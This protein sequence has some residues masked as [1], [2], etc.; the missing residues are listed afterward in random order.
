MRRV[1]AFLLRIIGSFRPAPDYREEMEAHLAMQTDENIR[2]GMSPIEAR[3]AAL[4]QSGGV[5]RGVEGVHEQHGLPWLQETLGDV[6]YAWR[7]LRHNKLYTLVAV[8]TLAL[9]VGAN[10]AIFSVVNGVVLQPLPYPEPERLVSVQSTIG[11]R[12][13]SASGPD[14]MDWRRQSRTL[15]AIA[16]SYTSLHETVLTGS[17]EPERL[18]QV[19][20]TANALDVLGVRPLLGRTFAA[21]E[22][23]RGAPRVA[24]LREDLWT[25]RF[26]GDSSIV[27]RTLTFDGYPTTIIGIVPRWLRWPADADVYMTTR[28]EERDL[29]AAARG[30]RWLTV[31]GRLRNGVT[32]EDAQSE[33][34]TIAARLQQLDP[35]HNADVQT[36]VTPLLQSMVGDLQKPLYVILGAVGFVLLVACANVASLSLGRIAAREPELAVRTALGASRWRI[37][38]QVLIE[39]LVLAALGGIVGA[40]VAAQGLRLLLAIAPDDL[41][42]IH[43]VQLDGHV[44][45]FTLALTV[46]AGILFGVTPAVRAAAGTHDRLRAAGRSGHGS[47]ES[48][49]FRRLLVVCEVAMAVVLVTG[50]GLLLRSFALLRAVD[51]GFRADGVATF[52]V[53]LPNT[54]YESAEQ[55]DAFSSALLARLRRLPGVTSAATSFVLPL[56]GGG[57]GFTFT[58]SGRDVPGGAEEPRAQ[59]R[60]AGPEYFKTMGI[61]LLRG[62]LYDARDRLG[63]AS[64]LVISSELANRYFQGEDPIGR[65]LET[66]WSNGVPGRKFG[67]EV[68]GIVGDV[69]QSTLE[70]GVSP[71]MYMSDAQWPLNDYDVVVRSSASFESVVLGARTALRELDPDI[72]LGGARPLTQLVDGALGTRRF[73]M[74]LLGA[75]AGVALALALVGIYGV[76]AYGVRLRRQEIGV[77]LALGASRVRIVQMVLGDGLRLVAIGIVAGTLAALALTRVLASLLYEVKSTD[78]VTFTLAAGSLVAAATLACIL[79]ARGAAR[80]DPVQTIRAD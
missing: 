23:D 45:A 79:P 61:P 68:I 52:A 17:G 2:R 27:G 47:R 70:S 25:R 16:A 69:R 20:V 8:S 64:V 48:G 11:E 7:A 71:H 39:N 19:R 60:V 10:T 54:R 57:F 74:L 76:M 35:V 43:D 72:P 4:L 49:R 46:L 3:R 75:F 5:T 37:A 77:R 32:L 63:G 33:L 28:F 24:L 66:G 53:S 15:G 30:A 62:R 29:A 38:R 26:G 22:D 1:R 42:R 65:Y 18:S 59:V 55:W 12:V 14:F 50:A 9:G 73:Y 67:G 56:S 36:R 51:P 80:L 6:R 78:P 31:V 44:L 34:S 58:I 41:P 40:V 13:L 21:G